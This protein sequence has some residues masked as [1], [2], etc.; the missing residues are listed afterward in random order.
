MHFCTSND[1]V[2]LATYLG[3]CI[4]FSVDELRIFKSRSSDGVRGIN[5]GKNDRVVEKTI[6]EGTN[7]TQEQKDLYLSIPIEVRRKMREAQCDVDTM[8]ALHDL[9][10]T[11]KGL[12]IELATKMA[13]QEQ[14]ILSITENGYGKCTSAYEYRTTH[15]G[16]GGVVNLAVSRKVGNIVGS[17]PIFGENDAELMIITDLGKVI[18]C[19]L[20]NVRVTGRNTSGVILVKTKKDEKVVSVSLVKNKICEDDE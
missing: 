1:H 17:I 8:K 15:R 9:G 12:S 18:R 13:S 4:R 3:K 7:Y 11:E 16:G 19:K 10:G 2:F 14:F 5:L 6:L 20:D